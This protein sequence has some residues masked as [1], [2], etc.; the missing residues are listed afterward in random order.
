MEQYTLN[1]M[2]EQAVP[3]GEAITT[4]EEPLLFCLK[5]GEIVFTL[6]INDLLDCLEYAAD[7]AVIPKLPDDWLLD[8]NCRFDRQEYQPDAPEPD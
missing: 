6:G 5:K 4:P 2:P 7:Q 3:T 1:E 8:V